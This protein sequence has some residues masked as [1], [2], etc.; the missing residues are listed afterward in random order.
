VQKLVP[1]FQKANFPNSR[2]HFVSPVGFENDKRATDTRSRWIA[3]EEG[4]SQSELVKYIDSHVGDLEIDEGLHQTLIE[5]GVFAEWIYRGSNQFR[6]QAEIRSSGMDPEYFKNLYWKALYSGTPNP[7]SPTWTMDHVSAWGYET[8]MA[9]AVYRTTQSPSAIDAVNEWYVRYGGSRFCGL[10]GRKFQLI[11]I[12]WN[13]YIGSSC[14]T[15]CC[16]ECRIVGEPA[17]S[18]LEKAIPQFVE[19]IGFIPNADASPITQSF[20]IR[21]EPE[22]RLE[23]FRLYANMGGLKHVKKIYGS[24]FE[25]LAHT[26]ALPGGMQVTKR[27]IRCLAKDGHVCRSMDE[28]HID[29]W[30]FANG[31]AHECEPHYPAHPELNPNG[32]LMAD[33]KVGDIFIEYFGMTGDPGYDAKTEK[34]ISLAGSLGI[35][36]IAIYPRDMVKLDQVLGNLK[37]MK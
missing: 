4:I 5:H 25:A 35:P 11:S 18:I 9:Q 32:G 31:Y 37:G 29:N 3:K 19:E 28:Q 23:V 36:L 14:E 13:F 12:T 10:C 6:I 26:G 21:I 22:R 24:W 30:L 8:I 16:F 34:K 1:E 20:T 27:G 33:W 17:K 15:E 7:E 2:T